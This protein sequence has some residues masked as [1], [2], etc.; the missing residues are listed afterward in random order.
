MRFELDEIIDK[1][2]NLMTKVQNLRKIFGKE[3]EEIST[4]Y[5][6]YGMLSADLVFIAVKLR[7]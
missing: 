7:Q 2:C 4:Q 5:E 1:S 3:N 6:Q